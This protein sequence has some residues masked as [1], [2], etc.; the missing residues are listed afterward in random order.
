MARST[1]GTARTAIGSARTAIASARGAISVWRVPELFYEMGI[2]AMWDFRNGFN[3]TNGTIIPA[4]IGNS[5]LSAL[6]ITQGTFYTASEY[7]GNFD[8]TNDRCI[9]NIPPISVLP[10]AATITNYSVFG[11]CKRTNLGTRHTFLSYWLTTNNNRGWKMDAGT[12][13]ELVVDCSELGTAATI[14]TKTSDSTILNNTNWNFVGFSYNGSAQTI[15]LNLNGATT[16]SSVTAGTI[17]TS[18]FIGQQNFFIG[19][20]A[21]TSN[22]MDGKIGICG[23][24]NN[25]ALSATQFLNIYTSTRSFY[26]V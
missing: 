5:H 15:T 9:A 1:L 20:F 7:S 14:A 12:G 3:G 22:V 24:A 11:W 13:N 16:A 10:A 18:I 19:A 17:P 8:A 25:T 4:V 26:G 6:Q 2:T 23:I 21:P